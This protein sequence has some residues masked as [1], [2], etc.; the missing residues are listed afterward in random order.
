MSEDIK[1]KCPE[2]GSEE[3]SGYVPGFWIDVSIGWDAVQ[4]ARMAESSTEML[5]RRLCR[6]CD[7]E[8][9]SEL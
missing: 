3:V 4:V 2:C 5:D 8:W 1:E 9:E 7:H 6:E